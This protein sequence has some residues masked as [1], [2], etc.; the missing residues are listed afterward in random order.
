[1]KKRTFVLMTAAITTGLMV[2]ALA[3]AY[4]ENDDTE[5][6]NSS[7]SITYKKKK[8]KFVGA[9]RS[10]S[11]RCVGNRSVKVYKILRDGSHKALD[12]VKTSASGSWSLKA[13]RV[14]GKYGATVTPKSITLDSGVDKYGVSWKHVL[15]CRPASSTLKV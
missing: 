6:A 15:Q 3:P 12:T 10:D 9:V 1:M 13:R 2:L 7:V 4:A 11:D 8:S 5:T 14:R